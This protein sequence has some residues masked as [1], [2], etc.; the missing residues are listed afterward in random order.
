MFSV[1]NWSGL[2]LGSMEIHG[3]NLIEYN[4]RWFERFITLVTVVNSIFLAIYDYSFRINPT[5][6]IVVNI[7]VDNSELVFTIIFVTEFAAKA[8]AMS[9]ILEKGSYLRE[10]LNMLD[11][12]VVTFRYLLH[13]MHV[14]ISICIGFLH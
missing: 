10:S 13:F 3:S 6:H 2:S 14:L 9:F 4:A 1:K 5:K 12:G 11:F 8:L 7:L